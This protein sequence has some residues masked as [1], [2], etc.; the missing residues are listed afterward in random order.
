MTPLRFLKVKTIVK[1]FS[2]YSSL[3]FTFEKELNSSLPFLD[4]LVE[5]HKTGFITSVYRKSC[6]TGQY[7]HWDSFSPTKR[8]INL[9]T[10]LVYRAMFI[11]SSSRLQAELDK[12]RSI[13]VV[14]GYPNHII[15]SRFSKKI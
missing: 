1:N 15:T 5:K 3:R 12:I 9:V 10:T 7:V 14:N 4:V 6:F 13:L 8:K 11:C 2:F